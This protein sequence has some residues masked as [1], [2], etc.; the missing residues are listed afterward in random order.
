MFG[1]LSALK[2]KV[3]GY[4][5][6]AQDKAVDLLV[7]KLHPK[8]HSVIDTRVDGFRDST[9]EVCHLANYNTYCMHTS[10]QT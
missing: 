3:S 9:L 4:V 2:D 8:V 7:E 10:A 5:D 1:K 6:A